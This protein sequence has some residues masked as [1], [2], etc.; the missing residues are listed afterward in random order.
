MGP[1]IGAPCYLR[2]VGEFRYDQ[3]RLVGITLLSSATRG[4][5]GRKHV[6]DCATRS[7]IDIVEVTR[8]HFTSNGTRPMTSDKSVRQL[9]GVYA[10]PKRQ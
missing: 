3:A 5:S 6:H 2:G 9:R 1:R 4:E 7:F 8:R 10:L